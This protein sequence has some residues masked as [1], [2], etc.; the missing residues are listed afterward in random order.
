MSWNTLTGYYRYRALI[1]ILS[2]LNCYIFFTIVE[3]V[4]DNCVE[5]SELIDVSGSLLNYHFFVGAPWNIGFS[6]DSEYRHDS[7]VE[8]KI[9][10]I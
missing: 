3:Q 9:Q 10:R 1:Y 2:Q 8:N 4:N 7:V 5:P 6:T